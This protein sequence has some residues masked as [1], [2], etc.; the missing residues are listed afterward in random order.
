MNCTHS[1]KMFAAY[2]DD[3]T[4]Q[5]EREW[6]ETHFSS[7]DSCR[8][9]YEQYART[10]ELLASLPRIE[11]APELPERVL[12][13]VRRAETPPDRLPVGR[14]IWV[15][16]GSAIAAVALIALT[17]FGPWLGDRHEPRTAMRLTAPGSV[18][19]RGCLAAS[20]ARPA[21]YRDS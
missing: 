20:F 17:L 7:C 8:L 18:S 16:V 19:D 15:P 6:L 11:P 12:Q 1:R 2:W 4:T 9:E 21:P 14:P 3:E 5:A 10:L 13:R